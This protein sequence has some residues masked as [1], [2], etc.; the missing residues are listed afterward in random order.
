MDYLSLPLTLRK[1]FFRT[2]DLYESINHSI[3]LILSTRR[4]SLP[5]DPEFG[6]DLWEKEYSDLFMANRAEVQGSVRNAINRYEQRLFNVSVSLVKVETNPNHPLGLAVKIVGNYKDEDG[7][8]RF[9][10][11]FDVG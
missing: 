1:G 9:E 5:F 7:E 10:E 8:K 2:T 11:T 3:G 6:C 4:G